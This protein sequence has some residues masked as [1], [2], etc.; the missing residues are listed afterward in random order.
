MRRAWI[1][2]IAFSLAN[3]HPIPANAVM[4]GRS[5]IGNPYVVKLIINGNY[6]CT[7]VL[8]NPTIVVTAGH[9]VVANNSVVEPSA[10]KIYRPGVN[11]RQ[12]SPATNAIA[13]NLPSEFEDV[14]D[15]IS[16]NDI[17][18]LLLANQIL[19]SP[20]LQ[21]ADPYLTNE[22]LAN[23]DAVRVY[24]YGKINPNNSSDIPNYYD[25]YPIA[26]KRLR[27]FQ[28]YEH[29]YF[30]LSSDENGATCPGDSGGPSL[31]EYN[32]VT[33]LIGIHSGGI[34]PCNET[35][36]G[37]WGATETLVGEY[38]YLLDELLEAYENLKPK[39]VSNLSLV[40]QGAQGILSWSAPVDSPRKITS[41]E[42]IDSNSKVLCNSLD[43]KCS[44]SFTKPGK[45]TFMV[46]AISS[47]LRSEIT[48]IDVNVINASNPDLLAINTLQNRVQ[49]KWNAFLNP[50]NAEVDSIVVR[51]TDGKD[52]AILCEEKL[53]VSECY[54]PL[55]Q[56][57]YNLYIDLT[58]NLGKTDSIFLQRYSGV[59]ESS[60][61]NRV[62][63]NYSKISA[64][65]NALKLKNPGYSK[66]VDLLIV[67]IPVF[68]DNS[69]FSN[70]IWE[71][72]LNLQNQV[73]LLTM[74]TISKPKKIT[75]K[76]YKG[77]LVKNV[78]GV[79]PK[80]PAGY[81]K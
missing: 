43:L 75:I 29:T 72:S 11:Y 3:L 6:G 55:E 12:N 61:V 65:L 56:N 52:G 7:G 50:G 78:V 21:I 27:G 10:V 51:I 77:K 42:V 47:E 45:N 54:F 40:I 13:I 53:D 81:K 4:N 19:G 59:L 66:E 67:E 23:G 20:N 76:C 35:G 8:I 26:Q 79:N 60:L 48:S 30:N 41:Y 31:A 28:G 62:L 32:G 38:L 1:S 58:S 63:S 5:A 9:C 17:A 71:K 73:N 46:T 49:V 64:S 39:P 14:D 69:I 22:I 74:K 18:F 25:A 37:T 44:F 33:Y 36:T 57:T 15:K 80:C 24:G 34:G 68:D 70:D 2:L 16:P